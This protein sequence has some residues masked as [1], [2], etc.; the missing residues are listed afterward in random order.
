M[1]VKIT[2]H[3]SKEHDPKCY[4]DYCEVTIEVDGKL[5]R[6]YGDHYHDKGAERAEGYKD[7]LKDYCDP[8]VTVEHAS[9]ADWE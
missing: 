8:Q 5:V 2:E 3:F 4:G 9:V 6:T 1:N 7:A